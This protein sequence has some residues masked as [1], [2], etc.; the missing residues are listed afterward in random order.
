LG[1]WG[2]GGKQK[3]RKKKKKEKNFAAHQG[4]RG[5]GGDGVKPRSGRRGKGK[6]K[7]LYQGKGRKKKDCSTK[8]G[9]GEGKKS[10][11]PRPWKAIQRRKKKKKKNHSCACWQGE[12]A[13][14]KEEKKMAFCGGGFP[15]GLSDKGG[16]AGVA[17]CGQEK[18]RKKPGFN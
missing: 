12:K 15:R 3:E 4:K 2:G 10:W 14:K 13:R 5:K 16:G 9:R 7:G 18:K 11:P 1:W 8:G 6:E 17:K